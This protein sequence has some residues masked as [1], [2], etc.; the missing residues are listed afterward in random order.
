MFVEFR[1]SFVFI[2]TIGTYNE[3]ERKRERE[4]GEIETEKPKMYKSELKSFVSVFLGLF[5]GKLDGVFHIRFLQHTHSKSVNAH[6]AS[7]L[8]N[9]LVK[10]IYLMNK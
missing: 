10:L 7:V 9:R 5:R 1:M 3:R 2:I 4:R 8:L 6:L